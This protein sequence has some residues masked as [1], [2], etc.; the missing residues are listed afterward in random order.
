MDAATAYIQHNL[1]SDLPLLAD[2]A[3]DAFQLLGHA[4]IRFNDL[5]DGVRDLAFNSAAKTAKQSNYVWSGSAP[6]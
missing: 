1:V 6:A 2:H 3:A 5:I 4:F